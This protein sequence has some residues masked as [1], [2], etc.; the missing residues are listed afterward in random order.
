MRVKYRG[1]TCHIVPNMAMAGFVRNAHLVRDGQPA[2]VVMVL[3][4]R[5]GELPQDRRMIICFTKWPMSLRKACS[6][7]K[8]G[9]FCNDIRNGS[10]KNLRMKLVVVEIVSR[11]SPTSRDHLKGIAKISKSTQNHGCRRPSSIESHQNRR[12]RLATATSRGPQIDNCLV[13]RH[14]RRPR[15][16]QE[17]LCAEC[18][19]RLFVFASANK[20]VRVALRVAQ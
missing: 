14:P 11:V 13:R 19:I 18:K 3:K 8:S 15:E 12:L 6:K 17:K 16:Q 7:S 1:P 5:A 2:I 9:S 10:V 4:E 20:C